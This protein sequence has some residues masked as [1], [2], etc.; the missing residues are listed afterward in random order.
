MPIATPHLISAPTVTPLQ[1]DGVTLAN[2]PEAVQAFLDHL[3]AAIRPKCQQELLQLQR[4][5]A[6][7]QGGGPVRPWDRAYL[8]SVCKVRRGVGMAGGATIQMLSGCCWA[9]MGA[10]VCG[11]WGGGGDRSRG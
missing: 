11:G 7:R 5:K 10:G 4:A 3:S 2:R 9:D 6:L 8:M 1:L